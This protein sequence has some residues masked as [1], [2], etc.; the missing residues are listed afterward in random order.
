MRRKGR[1]RWRRG[2]GAVV[3][4]VVPVEGA[5]SRFILFSVLDV[6]VIPYFRQNLGSDLALFHFQTPHLSLQTVTAA[7]ATAAHAKTPP[8]RISSLS[9]DS[10]AVPDWLSHIT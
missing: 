2:G 6:S 4:V 5:V 7:A 10:P 1:E 9:L 3:G 8:S